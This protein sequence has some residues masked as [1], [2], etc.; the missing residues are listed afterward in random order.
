MMPG[1][2]SCRT[3][4]DETK[5]EGGKVDRLDGASRKDLWWREDEWEWE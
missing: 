4:R 2:V 1:Q 5:V 3:R